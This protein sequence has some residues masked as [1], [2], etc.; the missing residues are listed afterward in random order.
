[1]GDQLRLEVPAR[2]FALSLVRLEV[3]GVAAL[4]GALVTEVED[5]QLATEELCLGLL[6]PEGSNGRLVVELDWDDQEVLIRCSLIGG[7]S[8][9]GSSHEDD[10]LPEGVVDRILD[11]LVDEHGTSIEG[12][13]SVR[14]LRK[15]REPAD[16]RR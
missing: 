9:V 16:P 2:P 14:W 8:P 7:S 10:A 3:S 13:R 1:M 4:A 11:S 5:L 15:R 6:G 12:D